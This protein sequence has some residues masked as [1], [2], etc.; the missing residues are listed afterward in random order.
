MYNIGVDRGAFF[1]E[2]H[3]VPQATKMSMRKMG[4][5]PNF[6]HYFLAYSVVEFVGY[7]WSGCGHL[8]TLDVMYEAVGSLYWMTFG[9]HMHLDGQASLDSYTNIKT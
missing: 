6:A 1:S 4:Q 3:E 2:S 7:L 5:N 9:D 8:F